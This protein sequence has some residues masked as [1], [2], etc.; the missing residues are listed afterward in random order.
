MEEA[1]QKIKEFEKEL[2]AVLEGMD[3]NFFRLWPLFIL[4]LI[5]ILFFTSVYTMGYGLGTLLVL[6]LAGVVTSL[7]IEYH[8]VTSRFLKGKGLMCSNCGF[9]PKV[10]NAQAV[11]RLKVCPKCESELFVT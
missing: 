6:Y 1:D 10:K 9:L 8:S 5:L 3:K 7:A 11:Y 4:P 2:N